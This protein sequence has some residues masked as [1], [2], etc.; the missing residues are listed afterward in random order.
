VIGREWDPRTLVDD[1]PPS[2][3]FVVI[4]FVAYVALTFILAFLHEP[5]RDEADTWLYVRDA[6]VQT[7][8]ARTGYLGFPALWYLVLSP[9]PKVGLPYFS[10]TVVHLLV[11]AAAM[12]I[13]FRYA[14]FSRL[15][16]LLLAFSYY[17]S[18][19]YAVVV[20][21][22][23]LSILLAFAAAA[24]F[25]RRKEHPI[26]FAIVVALLFNV[27][28]QGFAIAAAFTVLFGFDRR[29]TPIM[30][31]AAIVSWWQVRTPADHAR[32]ATIHAPEPDAF[33][34]AIGNAFLPTI[35]PIVG[36][37]LGML[38]LLAI[39]L[40]I[41]R[42]REAL[43]A[44]WMPLAGIAMLHVYIWIGG[45]RHAGFFLVIPIV[46]L[47]IAGRVEEAPW[48]AVL[49]NITL[50][51]SCVVAVQQWMREIDGNFSGSK[52]MA[53]FIRDQKLDAY[54]IAA[55]NLT[56]CESLLPYLPGKKFWYAGLGEYGSYMTWDA[57]FERALNVPY[58][59]AEQRARAKFAG[60]RWLLLFNVEMPDPERHGFRLL[61]TNREP[62]FEKTDERYWL[63]APLTP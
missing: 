37:I 38:V 17:F 49:L 26:A 28:P 31:L 63:Y 58:P 60:K 32:H 8:V 22:Y 50:A 25:A 5:W 30:V 9:L 61:Y 6:G 7:I 39:T 10:Q 23:A 34:W 29:A 42:S 13:L 2:R 20:R 21:T 41:R 57:A 53:M 40:A 12:L 24:L 27:N 3:R 16:K 48:A 45:L 51:V 11:A 15:T 46:A 1:R 14:P 18:Y 59:V 47:W 33:Q 4:A 56:Q 62:I 43:L 44:L 36:F 55:H 52:E 35:H 54:E 19:E